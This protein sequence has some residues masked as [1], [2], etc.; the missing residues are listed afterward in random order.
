ME[1]P[2]TFDMVMVLNLEIPDRFAV[3]EIPKSEKIALNGQEG[4]FEYL[5][6]KNPNSIQLKSA[7]NIKKSTFDP[8]DYNTL[9]NFYAEVIKKQA[10]VIV[11]K[12]SGGR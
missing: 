1:F 11:F 12:K 7:L 9:R 2:Y 8:E 6:Q 3:D 10:E 5:I 4:S